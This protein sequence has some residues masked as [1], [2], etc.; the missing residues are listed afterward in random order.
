MA[1]TYFQ[2]YPARTDDRT[3]VKMAH[4]LPFY[5]RLLSHLQGRK[6]S[7]LEIG[8]FKGGSV[9]MWREFFAPEART[10]FIDINPAC[11]ALEI[12]GT[13]IR[14]GDQRDVAFLAAVANE[15]GPFDLIVD[16]GGHRMDEQKVSFQTLWPHLKDGGL[17]I[18]EDTHTSY[19]PGFGGGFRAPESF[20]EFAKDLVDR[21]HSW[22]T[23]DDAGF[24]LHP[25]ARELAGVQFYDSLVI[26]EK[27]Q[28][29][30]PLS[31]SAR[32]GAVTGSHRLLEI[33]GRKSIF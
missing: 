27:R 32:N 23:D 33:R 17:Y 3:L 15:S 24:P 18:V 20:V 26:F 19:W 10:T 9:R 25:M 30:P 16:D 21:M 11:K 8:V 22:Y 31:I 4:Y 7:F 13:E 12:A 2:D 1:C 29:G 14:I 5:D 6:V 28:H